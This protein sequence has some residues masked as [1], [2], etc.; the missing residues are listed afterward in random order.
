MDS[1]QEELRN[2]LGFLSLGLGCL[3]YLFIPASIL[4]YGI[5]GWFLGGAMMATAVLLVIGSQRAARASEEVHY[6]NQS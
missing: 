2:R 5:Y 1:S 3:G 4:L 6:R